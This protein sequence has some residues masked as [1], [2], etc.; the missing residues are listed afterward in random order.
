M[1]IML[2]RIDCRK[3]HVTV[4]NRAQAPPRN[5]HEQV[6]SLGEHRLLNN[7]NSP[8][9]CFAK[10]LLSFQGTMSVSRDAGKP[11]RADLYY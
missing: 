5:E 8:I 11:S 10:I 1:T 3:T 9:N 7:Y 4:Y 2:Y 6:S